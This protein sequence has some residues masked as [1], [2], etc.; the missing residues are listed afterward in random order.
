MVLNGV[1]LSPVV[2]C[3]I[4]LGCQSNNTESTVKHPDQIIDLT[5][6][7]LS[8]SNYWILDKEHAKQMPGTFPPKLARVSRNGCA[9][10]TYAINSEGEVTGYRVEH[11]YPGDYVAE[12]AAEHLAVTKWMPAESNTE[13]YAVLTTMQILFTMPNVSE[14]KHQFRE[15]CLN[16]EPSNESVLKRIAEE[17]N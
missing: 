17:A 13:R 8:L 3:L 11:S 16:R 1:R 14:D 12:A 10:L 7:D 6:G 9:E 4:L 2:L 5:G 15:E